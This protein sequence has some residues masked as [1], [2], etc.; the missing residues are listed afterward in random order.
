MKIK[1]NP[2]LIIDDID[3]GKI[4]IEP[5]SGEGV[6]LDDESFL[7]IMAAQGDFIHIKS[8]YS[9]NYDK[10]EFIEFIDE[11]LA[12]KILLSLE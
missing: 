12:A 8:I 7:V 9:P 6:F 2:E 5:Q 11:L 10:K 4:I 3:N 1:L